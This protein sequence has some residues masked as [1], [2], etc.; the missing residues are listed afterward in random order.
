MGSRRT[1]IARKIKCKKKSTRAEY[2]AVFFHV[3]KRISQNYIVHITKILQQIYK[4]LV[5]RESLRFRLI[6]RV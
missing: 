6:Y 3:K 4:I 5:L 1:V 2:T